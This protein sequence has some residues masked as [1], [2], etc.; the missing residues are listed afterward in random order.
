MSLRTDPVLPDAGLPTSRFSRRGG[1]GCAAACRSVPASAG[2]RRDARCHPRPDGAHGRSG[3]PRARRID[4]VGGLTGCRGGWIRRS[5]R[6]RTRALPRFFGMRHVRRRPRFR[7]VQHDSRRHDRQRAALLPLEGAA[8]TIPSAIFFFQALASEPVIG[9][10]AVAAYVDG[11]P[12][13]LMR[14]LKSVLGSPLI[15]E[16]T[17]V[18]RQ[19]LRFRSVIAA[20]VGRVKRRAETALGRDL[21][22]LVHGRPCISSTTTAEA[23][24]RA[25]AT[26]RARSPV[27]RGFQEISFQYEPIAAGSRLRDADRRRATG[28]VADIGGGTSDFSVVRLGAG[29]DD[30]EVGSGGG[31]PRNDGISIGGHRLRPPVQPPAW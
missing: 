16:T 19:R 10:A 14:A 7:N 20:Y 9:R 26:L 27:R 24:A 13:R 3:R 17:L 5:S 21:T 15:E 23:D 11:Q 29:A 18:G 1:R 6:R 4:A 31:H 2:R 30:C 12:G 22:H 25:E 8:T 28:P